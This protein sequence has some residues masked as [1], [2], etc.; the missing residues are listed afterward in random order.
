[1]GVAFVDTTIGVVLPIGIIPME[2][3]A[4]A[5]EALRVLSNEY[6]P[7][8]II[9]GLPRTLNGVESTEAARIKERVMPLVENIGIPCEWVDERFT[10]RLAIAHGGTVS[11]DER[12]AMT[13]L[14]DYL[15][16]TK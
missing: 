8:K 16:A 10:T 1:M 3:P 4:P 11:R 12:A 9:I 13:I 2:E 5:A 14:E 6:H 15:T 7:E